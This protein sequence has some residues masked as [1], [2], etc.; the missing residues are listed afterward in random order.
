MSSAN[1]DKKISMLD[2]Q[3][4]RIPKEVLMIQN[5]LFLDFSRNALVMFPSEIRGMTGLTHL[6]LEYNFITFIPS[7]LIHLVQLTWFDISNNWIVAISPS[8]RLIGKL[9]R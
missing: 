1:S 3:L 5:L 2:L 9:C 6:N 8:L 7:F 4:P